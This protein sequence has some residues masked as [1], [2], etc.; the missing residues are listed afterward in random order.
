MSRK[1][2]KTVDVRTRRAWRRWLDEHHGSE[3]AAWL[4]FHKRHTGIACMSYDD[5]V[6]EALC[7]GW[8]D[9]IIKRL[10]EDRYA[11]KFTPRAPN[12]RWSTINRKRYADLKKRG[13]LAPPGLARLP[14]D[15]SGD[16]P[17]LSADV[18]PPYFK[19]RLQANAAAWNYF[20]SLAPSYRTM[21]IAWVEA[22]KRE[23]TR[24][25]RIRESIDLLAAGKKL[26]MK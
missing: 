4:I 22:A 15:R 24:E 16:P 19:E 7:F 25:R 1:Q 18:L 21:Y 2:I 20:H 10:D 6:E 9:S 13:L 14:T 5:A 17:K 11:R 8:V 12:S 3:S 23:E 26:G